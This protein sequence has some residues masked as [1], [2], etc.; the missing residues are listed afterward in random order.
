MEQSHMLLNK[1][2]YCGLPAQA[3]HFW[4][5]TSPLLT[6]TCGTSRWAPGTWMRWGMGLGVGA[7]GTRS[8]LPRHL[9]REGR[10]KRQSVT[11]PGWVPLP[12]SPMWVRRRALNAGPRGTFGG[13]VKLS[14][15]SRTGGTQR[16]L[17]AQQVQRPPVPVQEQ[18]RHYLQ[19][20]SGRNGPYRHLH[21]SRI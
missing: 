1:S 12:I 2:A 14:A 13:L 7:V 5:L 16:R 10:V 18:A 8:R 15:A 4:A 6:S 17:C 21:P 11:I 9:N 20:F 3:S 19:R